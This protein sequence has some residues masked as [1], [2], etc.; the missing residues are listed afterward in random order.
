M[1]LRSIVPK[2]VIW[3]I[4]AVAVVLIGF[5]MTAHFAASRLSGR[6]EFIEATHRLQLET[7]CRILKSEGREK[8]HDYL[9][10]LDA[11]FLGK[12]FL[13]DSNNQDLSADRDLSAI[14][15][16]A[17]PFGRSPDFFAETIVL[18]RRSDD[19]DYRLLIEITP[20][21]SRWEILPYFAWILVVII[22]MGY[23]FAV[24][25]VR[26]LK[27]LQHA[28]TQ[29][30]SGRLNTRVD[31]ERRDEFGELG[32]AFDQMAQRIE[33][34]LTAE[35]LLLQDISHELRSPLTRL[36]FALDLAKGIEPPEVFHRVDREVSRLAELIDQLLQL[37]RAEGDV[38]A[39]SIRELSL[40]DLISESIDDF[41]LEA[42]SKQCPIVLTCLEPEM[43]FHGEPELIRRA[44]ENVLSNALRHAPSG[45]PVTVN[46]LLDGRNAA[47]SIR[48]CGTGVPEELLTEIF[49]PF[50]RV[51]CDR[52][53]DSGGVGLGLS[54]AQRAVH[55]HHGTIIARN[56]NPGLEVIFILPLD[57]AEQQ[58][59]S[60]PR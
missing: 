52:N 49:K 17:Q 11:L 38:T 47:I 45:S 30:G 50:R 56:A 33:S 57:S 14:A 26:P 51:E 53:R 10:R 27:S 37:T 36:R 5:L 2:T 54:I 35:R 40:P 22:A 43:I 13:V 25:I 4:G 58:S 1:N 28:V 7:A 6:I 59:T 48:D 39:R 21:F 32:R 41:R 20:P 3:L 16:R 24:N 9:E 42:E 15:A 44:F 29:L 12:H 18:E 60:H 23:G 8:L 46:L 31:F 19:E 55:L 34:L